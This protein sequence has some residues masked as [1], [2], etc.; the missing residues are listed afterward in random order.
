VRNLCKKTC[1][2]AA[3]GR[4]REYG[5]ITIINR[6]RNIVRMRESAGTDKV[7]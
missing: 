4:L 7:S 1:I 6:Q 2:K 5:T 3:T